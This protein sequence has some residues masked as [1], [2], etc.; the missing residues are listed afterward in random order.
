MGNLILGILAFLGVSFTAWGAW[1]LGKRQVA[2]DRRKTSG[3]I[4]TSDAAVLWLASGKIR[5]D[6]L[7]E[8]QGARDDLHE[9]T[10]QLSAALDR[11]AGLTAQVEQANTATLLAISEMKEARAETAAL[12]AVMEEVHE[13]IK[14]SNSLTAG[15]LL[16]NTETRRILEI[17][18]KDRTKAEREH[19]A[20]VG[21]RKGSQ[22]DG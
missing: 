2:A 10:T 3:S 8:L 20:E 19:L 14:T 1:S 18:E 13:E 21:I 9:A 4:E 15:A 5:E 22:R 17:P 16:D 7:T 6:L 12:R 11:V